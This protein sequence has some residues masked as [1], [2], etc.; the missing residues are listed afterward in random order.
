MALKYLNMSQIENVHL[1]L[2]RN[3]IRVTET[4]NFMFSSLKSGLICVPKQQEII[5]SYI[6]LL[7]LVEYNKGPKSG[8][9]KT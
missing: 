4:A 6:S 3:S 9:P 2:K 7:A 8:H 5:Q 1:S